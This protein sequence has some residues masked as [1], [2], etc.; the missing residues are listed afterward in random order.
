MAMATLMLAV[1]VF[2]PAPCDL[3]DAPADFER[4]HRVECGWVAVPRDPARTDGKTLRLWTARIKASGPARP[5]PILYVN[6]GP[7]IATVDSV[8]PALPDSKTL[9]MLRAGRDVILFDQRGSGRSEERMCPELGKQMAAVADLGLDPA[10]E[11]DRTRE[12][13][14]QCRASLDAQGMDLGAYST[15]ATVADM[16]VLRKAFGAPQ[17]NLA[18]VSYGTLVAL[19]AMRMHP[20]S[21]R[22]AILNSPYPPNSFAWAEQ[23]TSTAEAYRAIGRA[24]SAQPPCAQKFGDVAAKL[25]ETLARLDRTPVVDGERRIT[26]RLFASALWPVAVQSALLKFVPLAIDRAHAG[27]AEAIK[28]LVRA[29][30]SGNAF[31]E[32]SRAQGLAI[33]C[34]EGGRTREAY[35]RARALYP[36]LVSAAP[37]DTWD[38]LCAAYRPDYADASFFAPVASAIPTLMYAGG[39]DPAV[40]VGDAYQALRFLE[41]ATVVEVPDAAHAPM[42][43]DE[44]TR[45]IGAAFLADPL[46]TPDLTCMATRERMAFA[47]DGLAEL[48]TPKK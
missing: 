16:E 2:Q 12:L 26:G 13:F 23:A 5:D 30:A 45:G 18:A 44:C 32:N 46:R 38:R 25:E 24:C 42:G 8:L 35:A 3:K 10:A 20:A 47:L 6:G 37:D 1:G 15:R 36:A 29:F 27:D 11:E 4:S 28:G 22:S 21:V 39:L 19:D 17:W 9:P 41:N 48:Y 31:G 43:R 14:V 40:P 34:H 7:G 33:A